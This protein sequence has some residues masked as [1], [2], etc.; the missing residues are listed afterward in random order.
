MVA[1]EVRTAREALASLLK[2]RLLEGLDLHQPDEASKRREVQHGD[3]DVGGA[4]P[5][6]SVVCNKNETIVANSLGDDRVGN[7]A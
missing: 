5:E 3:A 7:F 6:S 2:T 4:L 1:T